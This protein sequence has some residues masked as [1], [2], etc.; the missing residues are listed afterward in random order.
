MATPTL[1]PAFSALT[2]WSL[3]AHYISQA[4]PA[5]KCSLPALLMLTATLVLAALLVKTHEASVRRL[6]P[7]AARALLE[8]SRRANNQRL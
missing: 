2:K 1:P 8:D 3:L 6:H 5:R 4:L 7:L